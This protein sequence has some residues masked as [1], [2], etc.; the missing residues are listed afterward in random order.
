[1]KKFITLKKMVIFI[2]IPNTILWFCIF[3]IYIF[4]PFTYVRISDSDVRAYGPMP[5][6]KFMKFLLPDLG[7]RASFRSSPKGV[8][9]YFKVIG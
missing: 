8:F 6:R 7:I 9:M 4:F 3:F 2:F 5:I 1:M